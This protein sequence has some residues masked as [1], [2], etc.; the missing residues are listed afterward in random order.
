MTPKPGIY[1]NVTYPEYCEWDAINQSRLM[2][3]KKSAAH[4]KWA[5]ENKKVETIAFAAGH[6][7]HSLVLEPEQFNNR[8]LLGIEGD[9][10]TKEVKKARAQLQERANGRVIL[11]PAEWDDAVAVAQSVNRHPK[12]KEYIDKCDRELSI[13]WIDP[14]TE[15]TCKARLDGYDRDAGMVI[16][17]KSTTDATPSKFAWSIFSFNY[18]NQ[19]AYYRAGLKTLGANVR[20]HVL[21][22][23]E[24]EGYHGVAVYRL[25]DEILDIASKENRFLMRQYATCVKEDKWPGYSSNVQDIGIPGYKAAELEEKYAG[26][27]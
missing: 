22:A 20:H 6:A 24:K 17:L 2:L 3:L 21:I 18:H 5:N 1:E 27:Y 26:L 9:G 23:V 13:L 25:D 11:T 16:D 15:L 10:R 12:A 8:Y 4:L 14:A 19:A 7:I